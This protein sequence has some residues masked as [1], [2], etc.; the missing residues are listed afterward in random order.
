MSI[1]NHEKIEHFS[2]WFLI[3]SAVGYLPL[4]IFL[5]TQRTCM[6]HFGGEPNGLPYVEMIRI[7]LE[8]PK[9]II[10]L[11]QESQRKEDSA[12]EL[13]KLGTLREGRKVLGHGKVREAH[14]VLRGVYGGG[15]IHAAVVLIL[16]KHPIP[17][18]GQEEMEGTIRDP[19]SLQ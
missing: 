1:G 18:V 19:T 16:T 11:C 10:C 5:L 4:G 9:G 12:T 7:G 6:K 3:L 2:S 8:V 17:C 14:H 15:T 13:A